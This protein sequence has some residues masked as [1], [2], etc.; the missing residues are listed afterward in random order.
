MNE[1]TRV[2]E[3]QG[4]CVFA[5]TELLLAGHGTRF[6]LTLN[7]EEC[8]FRPAKSQSNFQFGTNIHAGTHAGVD[9]SFHR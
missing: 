7:W 5:Q 4:K 8:R 6:G 1:R 3:Q 9:S 2:A